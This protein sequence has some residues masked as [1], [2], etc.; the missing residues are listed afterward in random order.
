MIKWYIS[1]VAGLVGTGLPDT[2]AA[3]AALST[4]QLPSIP[5]WAVIHFMEM[6]KLHDCRG[7]I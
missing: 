1:D 6:A 4:T 5:R 7:E 2:I 3:F